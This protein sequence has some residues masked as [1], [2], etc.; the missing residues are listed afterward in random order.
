MAILIDGNQVTISTV[1]SERE[2]ELNEDMIRHF[3]LNSV[4]SYN[5]RFRREFGEMIL[6][7]D[8][9][10][11]W[12][13][14]FFE[15]YKAGRKRSEDIDWEEF[16]RFFDKLVVEFKENLPYKVIKV[17]HAEGDDIIGTLC[18]HL[19][20]QKNIIISSD[21]DYY[22]LHR[23]PWV[24]QFSHL[25]K[26]FVSPSDPLLY[27]KENIIRGEKKAG[28]SI[29]NILS[30]SDSFVLGIRQKAIMQVKLD[31]WLRQEPEE[32]CD[33]TMLERYRFNER[34]IDLTQ[35]PES[36]KKRIVEQYES[37][38]IA[39]RSNL[40]NYMIKNRMRLLIDSI[41]DF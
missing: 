26:D 33:E 31:E 25:E 16:H 27:L 10:P 15:H 36:I 24:K 38:I 12:R 6:C 11:S 9:K 23:F 5:A 14:L 17:K 2:M 4:R 8:S 1:L 20:E 30:P 40:L 29:P 3:F 41:Q 37:G 28:D 21:R 18:E 34:L 35:T 19:K 32:F 7:F 13:H 22:Q 39:P